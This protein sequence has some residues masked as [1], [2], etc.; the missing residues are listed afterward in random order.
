MDLGMLQQLFSQG[1]MGPGGLAGQLAGAAGAPGGA[2]AMA[3]ALAGG[4]QPMGPLAELMQNPGMMQL[5]QAKMGGQG[6]DPRAMAAQRLMGQDQQPQM[7]PGMMT[8]QMNPANMGM[9]RPS[10][11]DYMA[12]GGGLPKRQLV[13]RGY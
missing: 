6:M 10:G 4:Q 3:G 8:P 1:N 2:G 5:L 9:G 11:V 7:P 13:N 12:Q